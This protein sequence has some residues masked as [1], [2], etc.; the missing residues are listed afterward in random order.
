MRTT[1]TRRQSAQRHAASAPS[2][3][4]GPVEVL[5]IIAALGLGVPVVVLVIRSIVD[6]SLVGSIGLRVVLDA[7]ALSLLTTAVSLVLTVVI[8]LP[9][10]SVLARRSFRGSTILETVID[11][12]IVLPL[13]IFHQIQLLVCAF[14]ARRYAERQKAQATTA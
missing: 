1:N 4:P 9:L 3:A 8:G 6:G 5:A 13:M 14:V 12:P 11:L 10:A 7:L 2:R